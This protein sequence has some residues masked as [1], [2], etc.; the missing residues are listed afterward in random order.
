MYKSTF[1]LKR[2]LWL[3]GNEIRIKRGPFGLILLSSFAVLAYLFSNPSFSFT[4]VIDELIN[5]TQSVWSANGITFFRGSTIDHSGYPKFHL[6]FFPKALMVVCGLF[7][8]M[9][10]SEYSEDRSRRFYLSIPAQNLEKWLTKGVWYIIIFPLCFLVM[11]QVFAFAISGWSDNMDRNTI[12]FSMLDPYVWRYMIFNIG[13]QTMI[14]IGATFFK[15]YSIAKLLLF[16]LGTYYFLICIRNVLVSTLVNSENVKV[17]VSIFNPTW[18]N[19]YLLKSDLQSSNWWD[20]F[21]YSMEGGTTF[22]L[23][24]VIGAVLLMTSYWKFKEIEA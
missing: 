18:W 12:G 21:Q 2:V 13:V 4:A 23:Y 14:Y 9:S 17:P 7:T 16:G 24:A 10:F 15:K 11:Y 22:F 3:L 8:A 1:S 19:Q 6:D 5:P 20:K